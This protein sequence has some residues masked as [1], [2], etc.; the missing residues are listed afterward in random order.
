M[1]LANA[2]NMARQSAEKRPSDWNVILELEFARVIDSINR[3]A[4]LGYYD[5]DHQFSPAVN[6]TPRIYHLIISRL[7]GLGYEIDKASL[8]FMDKDPLEQ[9][10]T[11]SWSHHRVD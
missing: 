8:Y 5:V 2:Q 9:G 6:N 1:K 4:S 7:G 3:A 11:I 10:I